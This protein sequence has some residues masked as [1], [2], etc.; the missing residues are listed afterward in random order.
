MPPPYDNSRSYFKVDAFAYINTNRNWTVEERKHTVSTIWAG[1]VNVQ[2]HYNT[3]TW[4]GGVRAA[5][6]P[7]LPSP[8]PIPVIPYTTE[9]LAYA[10][11]TGKMPSPTT[12]LS[13]SGPAPVT[14]HASSQLDDFWPKRPWSPEPKLPHYDIDMIKA[15][16]ASREAWL[17]TEPH[18]PLPSDGSQWHGVQVLGIG[19]YGAAG[20]WVQTDT[21]GCIRDKM[22]I[23]EAKPFTASQWRDPKNWRD[24]LPREIRIHE[25]VEERRSIE[26]DS[27]CH[28]IR[29][30]G[31]RLWMQSRRYRLY[32]DFYPGGDLRRAMKNYAQNWTR[33]EDDF[34]FN[35]EEYLS[36]GFIWYTIRA[37]ATAC[38][39]LHRGTLSDDALHG[40][41]PITHLDLQLPNVL[42]DISNPKERAD[43]SSEPPYVPILADFGISFLSSPEGHGCTPS[44]LP[45]D[46]IPTFDTRYPHEMNQPPSDDIK[47]GEKTDVWGIGNIAYKLIMNGLVDQGPVRCDAHTQDEEFE[48]FDGKIPL[49]AQHWRNLFQNDD[50]NVLSYD[51][52]E[53]RPTGSYTDDLKQLVRRCLNYEQSKRPALMEIIAEAD[54]HFG[55]FPGDMDEVMDKG[56]YDLRQPNFEGFLIGEAMDID[57]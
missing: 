25:L 56:R 40:W 42:L 20:L 35:Q 18:M 29:S 24:R 33:N 3:L 53:C 7:G 34:D 15:N 30:R 27:C 55:E 10:K 44:D 36:E 54:R 43:T 52:P 23:K 47:L 5:A 2:N 12:S 19:G 26:P 21:T 32:L 51:C 46:F 22:V 13:P 1:N 45:E 11:A 37:L 28:L 49:A 48:E 6:T 14:Q 31:H 17:S 16:G 50:T 38:L 39:L 41:K 57:T 4:V 8:N 9:A